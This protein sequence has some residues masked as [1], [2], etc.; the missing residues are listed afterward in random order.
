MPIREDELQPLSLIPVA[1]HRVIHFLNTSN[2]F[3]GYQ[4]SRRARL[5][6]WIIGHMPL[7]LWVRL[8]HGD[9]FDKEGKPTPKFRGRTKAGIEQRDWLY[10]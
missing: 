4:Y 8:T 1:Q 6:K 7:K 3:G 2:K 10:E 5:I 9:E